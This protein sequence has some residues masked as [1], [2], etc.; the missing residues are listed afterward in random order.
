MQSF[1]LLILL[2]AVALTAFR[3][4]PALGGEP[5]RPTFSAWTAWWDQARG[6]QALQAHPGIASTVSPYWYVFA[7]DGTLVPLPGANAPDF[8]STVREAGIPLLPTVTNAQPA[9]NRKDSGLAAAVLGDPARR[10]R[11]LSALIQIARAGGYQ[12]I[13]INYENMP[14]SLRPAFSAFIVDLATALHAEGRVLAVTLQPKTAEPGGQNGSRAL[15]Y[16]ALGAAADL[17]RIMAY[18][19]SWEASE[20]GPVAPMDWVEE[21]A[22]YAASLI[23]SDRL[24]LGVALYGYEWHGRSGISR[25]WDE[26]MARALTRQAALRWDPTA[27]APWFEYLEGS[28][29]HVAWF[30]NA[31][32]LAYKLQLVERFGLNGLAAWRLGGEDP[33][34]WAMLAAAGGGAHA[35]PPTLEE[36]PRI[37]SSILR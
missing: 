7:A 13:D 20:P 1:R 27:R 31:E 12:G 6:L 9:T 17:V 8:L 16:A 18:D 32:S 26:L 10:E 35:T 30:E 19:Y 25:M 23:P 36:P 22:R 3:G 24:Q 5:R 34:L 14:E 4:A 2:I 28:V 15:D 21:V 37:R 11:H 33:G 29:H